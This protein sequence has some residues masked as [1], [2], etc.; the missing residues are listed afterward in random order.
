MSAQ[1]TKFFKGVTTGLV[2]GAA[3]TMLTDPITDRQR[4]RLVKKTEGAF[5]CMGEMIDSVIAMFR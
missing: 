5:K 3:I 1:T 2:I 4:H